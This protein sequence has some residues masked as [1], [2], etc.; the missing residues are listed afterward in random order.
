MD[1]LT[2]FGFICT[3]VACW[4]PGGLI[5][6]GARQVNEQAEAPAAYLVHQVRIRSAAMV[7]Q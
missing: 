5:H 6:L 1:R 7:Q 3:L 2:T 4:V